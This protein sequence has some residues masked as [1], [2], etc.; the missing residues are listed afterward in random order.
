MNTKVTQ[1]TQ[2]PTTPS[3]WVVMRS[4]WRLRLAFVPLWMF[5]FTWVNWAPLLAGAGDLSAV[6]SPKPVWD[7][8]SASF[9]FP[10]Q[11]L[12]CLFFRGGV[13]LCCTALARVFMAAVCTCATR[14]GVTAFRRRVGL[15]VFVE[16]EFA[17]G[18]PAA[19]VPS[20]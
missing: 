11:P 15:L 6:G 3:F 17:K 10:F 16:F 20:L 1:S 12:S 14:G 7:N 4:T 2:Q 13:R 5:A 18:L 8:G 9:V 19:P